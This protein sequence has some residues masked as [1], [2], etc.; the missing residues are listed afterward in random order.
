M[1]PV[2]T[3]ASQEL[4]RRDQQGHQ[5]ASPLPNPEKYE[6]KPDVIERQAI[7]YQLQAAYF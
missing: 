2:T 6:V 7:Q 5:E 4:R 1:N 3:V